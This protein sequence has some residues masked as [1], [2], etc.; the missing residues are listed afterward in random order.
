MQYGASAAPQSRAPEHTLLPQGY[1]SASQA[2]PQLRQHGVHAGSP[3]VGFPF[4]QG[5]GDATRCG[6]ADHA[7]PMQGHPSM[8]QAAPESGFQHTG[9]FL[10]Q[11]VQVHQSGSQHGHGDRNPFVD[12]PAPNLTE[13]LHQIRDRQVTVQEAV[14]RIA[15]LQPL[16][17]PPLEAPIR[18]K[19]WQVQVPVGGAQ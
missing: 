3:Y 5:A 8:F 6:A 11:S 17:A 13:L 19:A 16:E 9:D 2:P 18:L 1:Q 7:L 14:G 10:D 4:S 15:A 12:V